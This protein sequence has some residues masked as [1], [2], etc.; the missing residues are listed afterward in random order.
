MKK[1]K[2]G[3]YSGAVNIYPRDG[4]FDFNVV[5]RRIL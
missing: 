5:I 3:M 1:Q 2:S 4:D